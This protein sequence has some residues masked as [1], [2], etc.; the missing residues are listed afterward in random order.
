MIKLLIFLLI[1]PF[2]AGVNYDGYFGVAD[3]LDSI[4]EYRVLVQQLLGKSIRI[5]CRI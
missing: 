5:K 4:R 3:M 2:L 1:Q